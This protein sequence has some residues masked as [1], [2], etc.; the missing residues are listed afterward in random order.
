MP[1]IEFRLGLACGTAN[2]HRP[3]VA[4][5]TADLLGRFSATIPW[6]S[7]VA[8]AQAPVEGFRPRHWAAVAPGFNLTA[9]E[10]LTGVT[11]TM[12]RGAVV[13]IH[14]NDPQGLLAAVTG[15][16]NPNFR[17]DVVTAK[18]L[19]YPARIQAQS[20]A[21][22]DHAVT[23]PFGSALQLQVISPHL[24]LADSSGKTVSSSA[25]L[26]VAHGAGCRTTQPQR[27]GDE[28]SPM[29]HIHC[30]RKSSRAVRRVL[31]GVSGCSSAQSP[32]PPWGRSSPMC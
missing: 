7:Y 10:Q 11:I 26:S 18:G 15:P 3:R 4:A 19:H 17:F 6:R 22:Q 29:T 25:S 31:C 32:R 2:N 24:V 28:V 27:D 5:V 30:Y 23:I 16:F 8:C 1:F 13:P 14:V 9:G 21:G 20:A 12:A